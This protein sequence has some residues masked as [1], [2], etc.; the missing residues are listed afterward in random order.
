[1][2][3]P[4]LLLVA[5]IIF[6]TLLSVTLDLLIWWRHF[7]AG[8]FENAGLKNGS[9]ILRFGRTALCGLL[10][11]EI[12]KNPVSRIDFWLLAG[13]FGIAIIAD[14][15]LILRHQLITGI[16]LFAI[17]QILLIVRHLQKANFK[18]LNIPV[19]LSAILIGIAMLLF[20]NFLLHA[21]LSS[22]NLALP[23]GIYSGLLITSCLAAF[24]A[25][26]AGFL[27]KRNARLAFL[28]MLLFLLC[29]ITVGVGAAFGEQSFGSLI[30]AATG[31]FYT[32]SLLLLAFSGVTGFNN[33][34]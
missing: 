29:D 26:H 22:K 2:K 23:V 12:W 27:P 14:Y 3:K 8:I 10:I 7:H 18:I 19:I 17:M 30:R 25:M 33:S 4:T 16:A 32:P 24:A 11:F 28:A 20:S 34:R 15:F 9:E 31:I 13:A 5:V 1:M 21:P 6:I